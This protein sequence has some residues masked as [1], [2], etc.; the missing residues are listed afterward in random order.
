MKEML[1]T[2]ELWLNLKIS[3]F[4]WISGYLLGLLF[5]VFFGLLTARISWLRYSFGSL[6][7]ALSSIPKI[8]LIP[9]AML[10]FGLGESQKILLVAWGAFFP[11]WLNTQS[12][13]EQ[14]ETEY[15]WTA[16]SLGLRGFSLFRHIIFPNALPSIITGM[17]IG[18][19]TATFSLAAA[20]MSGAF[21]GLAHQVFY[22][23]EMFQT[24]RMMAGIVYITLF[25]FLI[26]EIFVQLS[27]I[28]LPWAVINR[29]DASE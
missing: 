23:H 4:R 3:S 22:S 9:I 14:I 7:N 10:W 8:V 19:S 18:I 24:D 16:K 29:S 5:G 15:I 6:F 17:R 1:V 2:G 25:S 12:G 21:T 26:N 27:R 11:I 28:L 20:E 13:S